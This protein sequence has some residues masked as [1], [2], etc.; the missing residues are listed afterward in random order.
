MALQLFGFMLLVFGTLVYNEIVVLPFLGFNR[1]T[2]TE[3][4]KRKQQEDRSALLD[5][6]ADGT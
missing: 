2:K 6:T 5:N 4:A 1:Y 3:L